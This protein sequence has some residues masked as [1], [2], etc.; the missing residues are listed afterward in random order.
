MK[1][2]APENLNEPPLSIK[3]KGFDCHTGPAEAMTP[4]LERLTS[5]TTCG[6]MCIA[7][8]AAIW[9]AARLSA[10]R[11]NQ[12]IYHLVAAVFAAM[13]S[14][15]C[16]DLS[17]IEEEE[18]EEFPAEIGASNE[19]RWILMRTAA[20]ELWRE[21]AYTPNRE[22][23]ELLELT[24]FLLSSKQKSVYA[25]WLDAALTRIEHVAT[26]PKLEDDA[27]YKDL[28]GT[29]IDA[30]LSKRWGS[31]LPPEILSQHVPE[32][33]L[34]AY[35]TKF[36]RSHDWDTNPFVTHVPILND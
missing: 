32:C 18:M 13:A 3:W 28:T 22:A 11:D 5:L 21:N 10:E 1:G 12:D 23:F 25:T 34:T 26:A 20:P 15:D 14:S 31:V 35:A 17:D 6:C 19:I 9:G 36:F 30:F 8:G 29:Q 4:L 2:I 7:A 16:L 27:W 24:K 33:E